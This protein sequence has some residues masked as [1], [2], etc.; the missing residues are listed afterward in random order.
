MWFPVQSRRHSA[1]TRASELWNLRSEATE[2]ASRLVWCCF[3][4]AV[5]KIFLFSF[6]LN[7][8]LSFK[9]MFFFM[10]RLK[11]DLLFLA[12]SSSLWCRVEQYVCV[13]NSSYFEGISGQTIHSGKCVKMLQWKFFCFYLLDLFFA[14][15][16]KSGL[17]CSSASTTH[18]TASFFSSLLYFPCLRRLCAACFCRCTLPLS[19]PPSAPRHAALCMCT[20]CFYKHWRWNKL[21]T[22]SERTAKPNDQKD[23][24]VW[25]SS[26]Q[27]KP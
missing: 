20:S 18:K 8:W 10:W 21:L 6:I 23:V 26:I 7:L 11:A 24:R 27:K 16:T 25:I 5:L 14:F 22:L 19:S 15:W 17:W 1:I 2:L 13:L 3:W 9:P 12:F 4:D